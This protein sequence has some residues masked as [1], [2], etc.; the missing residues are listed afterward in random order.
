[1]ALQNP[2][3]VNWTT[4]Q[5]ANLIPSRQK[6]GANEL[7]Q[8][9]KALGAIGRTV[10]KILGGPGI[11]YG[12]AQDFGISFEVAGTLGDSVN[13]RA[14][15]YQKGRLYCASSNSH[16]YRLSGKDTWEDL[17]LVA[18][19]GGIWDI[20]SFNDKLV[21]CGNTGYVYYL[22]TNDVWTSMGRP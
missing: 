10:T 15:T 5:G 13:L 8:N 2:T 14:F 22:S 20:V 7:N 6:T 12:G 16:A 11:Y 9:I 17:G 1:M 21:V 18:S 19:L 4:Q 3:R